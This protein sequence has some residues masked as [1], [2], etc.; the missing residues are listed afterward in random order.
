MKVFFRLV[1]PVMIYFSVLNF[2]AFAETISGKVDEVDPATGKVSIGD[3]DPVAIWVDGGAALFGIA[4]LNDL[5]AGDT[6]TID[7]NTDSEGNK[8]ASSVSKL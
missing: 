3:P 4:S 8:E 6:V 5:K 2:T 7:F 1:L